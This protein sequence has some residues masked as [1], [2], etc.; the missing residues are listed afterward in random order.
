MLDE[1]EGW[2]RQEA[3][4]KDHYSEIRTTILMKEVKVVGK[5]ESSRQSK[6]SLKYLALPQQVT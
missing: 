3:I 2:T 1:K 5:V 4:G 6:S